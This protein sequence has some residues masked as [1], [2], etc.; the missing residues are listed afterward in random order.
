MSYGSPT[1]PGTPLECFASGNCD[2]VRSTNTR[3][4]SVTLCGRRILNYRRV[5][6]TGGPQGVLLPS[7]HE[8]PSSL[9]WF[10]SM[11]V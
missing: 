10:A 5:K 6:M 2:W 8:T 3:A 1:Y 4:I 7:F 9:K 11:K